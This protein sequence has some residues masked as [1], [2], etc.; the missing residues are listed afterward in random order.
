MAPSFSGYP[1]RVTLSLLALTACAPMYRPGT[2]VAPLFDEVDQV[3]FQGSLST[4]GFQ[5]D[6]AWAPAEH[7]GLRAGGQLSLS[8]GLVGTG[9]ASLGPYAELT[10][11]VGTWAAGPFFAHD[12]VWRLQPR[13]SLWAEAAGGH[14]DS[15]LSV[16]INT[17]NGT[18][19]GQIRYVGNFLHGTLQGVAAM[20]GEW[21]AFGLVM[22]GMGYGLWHGDES[23]GDS[24]ARAVFIEPSVFLRTG[25]ETLRFEVQA[26]IW[27]PV[28]IAEGS[29]FG[30][31]W[32]ILVSFG[33]IWQPE[34]G[35]LRPG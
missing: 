16:Q 19:T 28:Y 18:S 12:R 27:L 8:G 1:H 33:L 26:G 29:E 20:E 34:L 23:D 21:V 6:V 15:T 13:L 31:P 25:P 22:R 4:G 32:P 2:G 9:V 17:T 24:L 11:G 14:A 35:V 10:L 3:Q 7:V 30:V 5:T